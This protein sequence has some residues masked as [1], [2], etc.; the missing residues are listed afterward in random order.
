MKKLI[1][2]LLAGALCIS[3]VACGKQP[4]G[5]QA[6]EPKYVQFSG[7]CVSFSYRDDWQ[8]YSCNEER[9]II[10]KAVF[11]VSKDKD[12]AIKIFCSENGPVMQTIVA[13]NKD[14]SAM[15][16]DMRK[17]LSTT[18]NPS[19]THA[20]IKNGV[21]TPESLI[22]QG[23]ICPEYKGEL[24][25]EKE[26]DSV[27]KLER[28]V[29]ADDGRLAPVQDKTGLW[30]YINKKGSYVIAPQFADARNFSENMAAVAT[31]SGGVKTWGYIRRDGT[32]ISGLTGYTSAGS[33]SGGLALVS[34][35][36]KGLHY[37]NTNGTVALE[38]FGI[39]GGGSLDFTK[40]GFAAASDFVNGYAVVA[41]Y[42][43]GGSRDAYLIGSDGRAYC[44]V[45]SNLAD[46]SFNSEFALSASGFVMYKSAGG[47][48]GMV[49]TLGI[50]ILPEIYDDMKPYGGTLIG[51]M[52]GGKYGYIDFAN[53]D[54]V[55]F[56]YDGASAMNAD[57][58]ALVKL[59]NKWG[60]VDK[61]GAYIVPPKF[62]D[63]TA[64]SEGLSFV[65]L[66]VSWGAIDKSGQ[67]VIPAVFNSAGSMKNGAAWFSTVEG[68]GFINADGKVIIEPSFAAARDFS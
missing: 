55:P 58:L 35:A 44:R 8:I 43:A 54:A 37:I 42:G 61:T 17:T 36:E 4:D 56:R 29:A 23:D 18:V 68:Y 33:F 2:L 11:A 26:I 20:N 41:L 22:K 63:A 12:I 3:A 52:L 57:G 60:V 64:F 21:I 40:T 39:E 67:I 31:E 24:L 1:A 6:E 10:G 9:S 25:T 50:R 46:E 65:K 5:G 53:V 32:Y 48:Y 27:A 45:G 59:D 51:A 16:S 38:P 28:V 13:D 34:T 49:D 62:D 47:K 7:Y 66:G 14:S 19:S 15:L 30:G